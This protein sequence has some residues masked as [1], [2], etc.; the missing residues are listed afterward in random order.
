MMLTDSYVERLFE[1]VTGRRMIAATNDGTGS[2]LD[3]PIPCL[4]SLIFFPRY[5]V[6]FMTNSYAV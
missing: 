2:N 4:L 3:D 6:D 1:F 5:R